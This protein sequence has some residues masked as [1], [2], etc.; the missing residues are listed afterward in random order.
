VPTLPSQPFSSVISPH[1]TFQADHQA[2]QAKQSQPPTM[3]NNNSTIVEP[4]E[5]KETI[6]EPPETKNNTNGEPELE[7]EN[8]EQTN[9]SNELIQSNKY[10]DG[11]IYPPPEI[12][13]KI[14]ASTPDPILNRKETDRSCI[15]VSELT[16]IVDKTAAFIAKNQNPKLCKKEFIEWSWVGSNFLFLFCSRG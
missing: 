2:N 5:Q 14:A 15:C 9:E 13:S 12:R 4:I 11:L 1:R 7:P 6:N 10:L 8:D 3:T 16:G